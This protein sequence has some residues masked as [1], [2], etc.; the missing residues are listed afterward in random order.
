MTLP[1]ASKATASMLWLR[2]PRRKSAK[3]A[4]C[5]QGGPARPKARRETQ[6]VPARY[7]A[8]FHSL[9]VQRRS[10]GARE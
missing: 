1:A 7:R 6:A 9:A 4:R 5:G 10:G 8:K 3:M 2:V